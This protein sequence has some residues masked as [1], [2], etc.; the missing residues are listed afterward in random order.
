M[1]DATVAT[2]ETRH[3]AAGGHRYRFVEATTNDGVE[4]RSECEGSTALKTNL[5][6]YAAARRRVWTPESD[7]PVTLDR[8]VKTI[9]FNNLQ[10]VIKVYREYFSPNLDTLLDIN[11]NIKPG[12][13]PR[14][15][16]AC[17]TAQWP[18]Q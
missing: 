10:D 6:A 12:N 17:P 18:N 4:G 1:A 5:F 3:C 14:I 11:F 7:R 2:I 13:H 9:L 15:L 16:H 8:I